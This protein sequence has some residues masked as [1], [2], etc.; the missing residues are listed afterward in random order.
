[1]AL[2]QTILEVRTHHW[3]FYHCIIVSECF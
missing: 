3:H 1:M 2:A